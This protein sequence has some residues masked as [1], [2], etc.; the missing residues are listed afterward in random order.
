MNVSRGDS[1]AADLSVTYNQ[2]HTE[3]MLL[4]SLQISA[5]FKVLHNKIH[6]I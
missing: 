2:A 4:N 5:Q 6:T 3:S 1:R